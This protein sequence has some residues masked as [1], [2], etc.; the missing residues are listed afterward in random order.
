[1]R[2]IAHAS[3]ALALAGCGTQLG[4]E[5]IGDGNRC[6][7]VVTAVAADAEVW[8]DLSVEDLLAALPLEGTV[9]PAWF[10]GRREDVSYSLA[11]D[12]VTPALQAYPEGCERVSVVRVGLDGRLT[13]TDEAL[14][15]SFTTAVQLSPGSEA[16]AEVEVEPGTDDAFAHPSDAEWTAVASEADRMQVLLTLP[17]DGASHGVVTLLAA[18]DEGAIRE[19]ALLDW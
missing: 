6:A 9:R 8:E 12:G 16:L 10:D 2:R 13:S 11:W 1:M 17:P 14:E 15:I 18:D 4:D 5:E 7:P 19:A 3:I